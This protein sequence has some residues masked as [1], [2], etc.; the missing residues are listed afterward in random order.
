MHTDEI[1]QL[2]EAKIRDGATDDEILVAALAHIQATRQQIEQRAARTKEIS[3]FIWHVFIDPRGNR[4]RVRSADMEAFCIENRLDIKRM[5]ELSNGG[6]AGLADYRGYKRDKGTGQ[7]INGSAYRTK[8]EPSDDTD[9]GHT[10]QT[11]K[12][13]FPRRKPQP[14]GPVVT[15]TPKGTNQP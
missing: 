14:L 12:Q 3:G 8:P 10:K 6:I 1:T 13:M 9:M 2:I 5:T 15:Y 4:V 11:T 7:W